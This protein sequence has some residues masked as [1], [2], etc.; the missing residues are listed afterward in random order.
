MSEWT[1]LYQQVILDHSKRPRNFGHDAKATHVKEGFNPL[2]GDQITVYLRV[3]NDQVTHVQFE[4]KGC[5][6][7]VASA[8]LMT[9]TIMGKSLAEIDA[10]FE[11]FH[12]LVTGKTSVDEDHALA[13]MCG[14]AQYPMRVK[15]ATLSWHAV[16]AAVQGEDKQVSTE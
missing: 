2:C 4:G 6:I 8:S 13:A 11:T 7:S 5:A 16:R 10:L 3:V 15:C 9:E 14:V 12:Q 1:E